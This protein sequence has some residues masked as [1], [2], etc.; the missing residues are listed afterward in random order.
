METCADRFV[1]YLAEQLT[2]SAMSTEEIQDHSADDPELTQVRQ[3][4][5]N[6]QKYKLPP[7]YKQVAQ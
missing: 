2:P 4:I 1:H 6:N 7:Q 3:C 5:I